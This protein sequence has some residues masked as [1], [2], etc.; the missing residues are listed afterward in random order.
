MTDTPFEEQMKVV[1][2]NTLSVTFPTGHVITV[3]SSTLDMDGVYAMFDHLYKIYVN[4]KEAGKKE[5]DYTG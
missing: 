4:H 5:P 3:A 2:D 1:G